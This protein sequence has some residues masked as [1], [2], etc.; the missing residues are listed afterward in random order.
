MSSNPGSP[1]QTLLIPL[2][3]GSPTQYDRSV[4]PLMKVK[5]KNSIH[6]VDIVLEATLDEI[7]KIRQMVG[8]EENFQ[9]LIR[10][11]KAQYDS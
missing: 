2:N 3:L 7:Y 4:F 10:N 6:Q 8:N 11:A 1:R 5:G 9:R